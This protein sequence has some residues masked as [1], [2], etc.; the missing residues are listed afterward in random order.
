MGNSTDA[1]VIGIFR[2]G[3]RLSLGLG[4][5]LGLALGLALGL[6]DRIFTPRYLR[7]SRIAE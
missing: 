6:G 1:I 2:S 3:V 7:E 5:G 4:L